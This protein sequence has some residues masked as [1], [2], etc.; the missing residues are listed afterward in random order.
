MCERFHKT[1][2]KFFDAAMHKKLYTD[3][4]SLQAELDV[5]LGH[6][7]YE[8][9]HS[10]KYCYGKTPVKTFEGGK[11]IAFEKNNELLYS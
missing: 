8:R 2:E 11:F 5:L 1:I 6:Y 10:G 3:L 7:N 9:L 4:A